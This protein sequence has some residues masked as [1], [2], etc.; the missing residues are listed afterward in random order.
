LH[1]FPH[2]PLLVIGVFI[3]RFLAI[4]PFQDGN[5]GLSRVVTTLLLLGAGY[6]YVPYSSLERVIEENKDTYYRALRRSQSTLDRGEESLGD[7]IGFFLR[8][9]VRQKDVLAKKL[10]LEGRMAA[11]PPLA[12][13]LVDLAR[14]HGRLTIGG[15]V[16]VTGANRNTIKNHLKKLVE[17]GRLAQCGRGRGTWYEALPLRS[18]CR[19]EM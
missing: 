7:W 19:A 13:K 15:A 10:E 16:E 1:L 14:R 4:H 5:G 6:A 18:R 3:V 9:L 11:L 8:C 2:H 12:E 17:S